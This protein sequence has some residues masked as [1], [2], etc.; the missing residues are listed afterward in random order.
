MDARSGSA[1][2]GEIAGRRRRTEVESLPL[3]LRRQALLLLKEAECCRGWAGGPP[4]EPGGRRMKI[5]R[6][7]YGG[8]ALLLPEE[9]ERCGGRSLLPGSGAWERRAR[10]VT[11]RRRNRPGGQGSAGRH[12]RLPARGGAPRAGPVRFVYTLTVCHVSGSV[13]A[14]SECTCLPTPGV[15]SGLGQGP[16]SCASPRLTRSGAHGGWPQRGRR[17]GGVW[18]ARTGVRHSGWAEPME[19]DPAGERR[20]GRRRVSGLEARCRA[21]RTAGRSP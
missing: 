3:Q 2:S 15:A 5:C 6:C 21:R 17:S 1:C 8:R 20:R 13:G 4:A 19:A 9:V 11:A 7:C 16:R 18:G 14:A 10:P 12:R